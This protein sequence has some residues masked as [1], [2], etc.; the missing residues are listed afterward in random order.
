MKIYNVQTNPSFGYNPKLNKQVIEKLTKTKNNKPFFETLLEINNLANQTEV[1][2]RDAEASKNQPLMQKL[3][4]AFI[5]LK[6]ILSDEI[7]LYFPKLK[8]C[9]KEI[10]YYSKEAE[11]RGL[12]NDDEH[13]LND[14]I[15]QLLINDPETFAAESKA[16]E[17]DYGLKVKN[18]EHSENNIKDIL[19]EFKPNENAKKGFATLGGMKEIK[20]FLY[21]RIIEPIKN[22]KQAKLDYEEYGLKMPNGLLLYGPTGCG[23]T[24]I[25]ERMSVEAGVPLYKIKAGK[26]GSEWI[27]KTSANI[28][29]AFDF[30]ESVATKEKPVILMI[31]EADGL[32]CA[33]KESSNDGKTEELNTFLDRI[34][35]AR[36][37]NVII[38]AAT[39][40]FDMV[41]EAVRNRLKPFYIPLPDKKARI[42]ILEGLLNSHKKGANIITDKKSLDKLANMF[43]GFSIRTMESLTE[44]AALIA[45]KDGRRNIKL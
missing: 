18:S 42:S 23:K 6:D 31:D 32:L 13:W 22:P 35:Q 2:L 19:I 40:K 45:K 39:N 1:R 36:E 5:G 43:E 11:E 26:I 17:T 29:L 12:V 28:E 14:I 30:A 20:D 33:R 41:D 15:E 38:I 4:S 44:E 9:K 8:Y 3:S 24:T 34:Q 21:D 27:H 25:I 7:E 37:N 10:D 16:A